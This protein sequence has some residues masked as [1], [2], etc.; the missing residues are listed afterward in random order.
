MNNK[1]TLKE[2]LKEKD[3]SL[4]MAAKSDFWTFCMCMNEEF[5][6]KRPYL[7]AIAE[8]YQNVFN[9]YCSQKALLLLLICHQELENHL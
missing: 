6:I 3:T 8:A 2:R 7:Y 9:D 4:I 1:K 5:F